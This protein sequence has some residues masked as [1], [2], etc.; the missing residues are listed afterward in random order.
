MNLILLDYEGTE[1][2]SN[3]RF[4]IKICM[5]FIITFN[6]LN[7]KNTNLK[8]ITHRLVITSPMRTTKLWR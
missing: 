3:A 4:E 5:P 7:K 2:F 1:S 8:K 6:S